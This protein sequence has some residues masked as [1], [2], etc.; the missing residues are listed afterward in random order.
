MGGRTFRRSA[1]NGAAGKFADRTRKLVYVAL[2]AALTAALSLTSVPMPS[3]V[4]V[5]LQTF[6]V[7]FAA[8]VLGW[9]YGAAAIL[10]YIAVGAAGA[11]VFSGFTGGVYKLVGLTGGFIWGFIPFVVLAGA[12]WA[13]KNAA[14]ALASA[15][16]GLA[17]CHILGVTQFTL[18]SGGTWQSAFLT[19]SLP[20]I[21]KDALSLVI[22]YK[23]A[24]AAGKRIKTPFEGVCNKNTAIKQKSIG[25]DYDQE[26]Q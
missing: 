4:P 25:G 2:F 26:R 7:A 9:K 20:Y 21:L 3:G 19:V 22:A 6:A 13:H 23:I 18:V 10:V 5:T 8:F 15:F 1:E 17:V 11:P 16:A 24:Q 14:A 12:P